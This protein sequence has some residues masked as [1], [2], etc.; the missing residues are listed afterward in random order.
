MN[1]IVQ[2]LE[3]LHIDPRPYGVKKLK[4]YTD[5]YRVRMGNYRIVYTINDSTQTITLL[6]VDDRKDVYR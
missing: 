3:V 5:T 4:G 6:N 1:R 2:L